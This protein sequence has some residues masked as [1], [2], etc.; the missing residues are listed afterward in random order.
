MATMK[1]EEIKINL[2]ELREFKKKNFEER[3][4]FI[5]FW[6]EYI[7]N[8]SDEDWSRQQNMLINSQ[9]KSAREIKVERAE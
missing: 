4:R 2:K 7:K 3:L 9:L 6:A 8:H 1:S 5:D